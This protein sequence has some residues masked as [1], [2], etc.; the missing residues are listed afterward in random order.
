MTFSDDAPLE[1]TDLFPLFVDAV[2]EYAIFLL[3]PDGHIV[4]WNPGAERIKGYTAE[5]VLGQHFSLFYTEQAVQ[6]G[7]P[8]HV[9]ETAAREGQWTGEGWRVR[10]DGSR[11]RA[12]VTVTPIADDDGD[13]RGFAKVS[14]EMTER[15]RREITLERERQRAER[16][17]KQ[18]QRENALLRLLERVAATA[19][20]VETL[21]DAVSETLPAVR[22][23]TGWPVGH[24]LRV[25]SENRLVSMEIWSG[26]DSQTL[27]RLRSWRE[28]ATFEVG[29]GLPGRAAARGAP[30]WTSD[31]APAPLST[32]D[33]SPAAAHVGSAT[34][35]PIC[36]R[37]ETVAVLEF[38]SQS[39]EE[40]DERLLEAMESVGLQL[41]RVAE[42]G[43]AHEEL[44]ESEAKFRALAEQSLLGIEMIQDG[45]YT[46]VNPT[47][48]GY[49]GYEPEEL[50]GTSPEVIIHPDEWPR[51][52]E[53]IR[54]RI[55][56]DLEE[57]TF[58]TRGQTRGGET[59]HL[60]ATGRRI[61]HNGKPALVGGSLDV[62]EKRR[63][64]KDLI[65]M[66]DEHQRRMGRELHDG[67]APLLAAASM[68]TQGLSKRLKQGETPDVEEFANVAEYI[69]NAADEVR[70]LSHGLNPPGLDLGLPMALDD[71]ASQTESRSGPSCSLEVDDTLPELSDTL[72]TQLYRIAQEAVNNAIQHADAE[73][74]SIRLTWNEDDGLVLGVEDDGRGLDASKDAEEGLGMRT[75]RHR[76]NLIDG[77]LTIEETSGGTLVQ[78]RVS[79]HGR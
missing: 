51:V 30:T 66:R 1:A 9:L 11:F 14:R 13:V 74:V 21:A 76:A 49:F 24:A 40:P 38:F 68:M 10:K 50:I 41:S 17:I 16:A 79:C 59:V 78:C 42:R 63:L 46:Y 58:A 4:S 25:D 33:G 29:N 53:L 48:A 57:A 37:G 39:E 73:H 28:N 65:N 31:V 5:E 19:N 12:H 64:E 75:M 18:A 27:D 52:K 54:R 23:H 15:Y 77:A 43:R 47:F 71:L 60:E 67:V 55:E 32:E 56:G 61:E 70:A 35:V 44:R 3:D 20:R 34:A 6:A 8:E 72:A 62:T 69:Q 36:L 26:R 7:E 45:V 22:R 2:Q